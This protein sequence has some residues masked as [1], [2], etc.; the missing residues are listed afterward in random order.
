MGIILLPFFILALILLF[1]WVTFASENLGFSIMR[2]NLSGFDNSWYHPGPKWKIALW[3]LINIVFIQ[4]RQPFS[5]LRLFW[6]K[7]FG[8]NI[9]GKVVIRP[10]VRVKYPWKLHISGPVWIGED[11]WIDN[12]DTVR[13]DAHCCIS[14]GAMLLC[15]NH[16]YK[17]P[18]FDL[19][20]GPIILEEGVWIGA[21]AVVCPGT[22]CRTHS[23][24]SVG[25]VVS[26][27]MLAFTIYRGNPAVP[28]R[29]RE[30]PSQ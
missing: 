24:L 30:L 12:L 23:I 29:N 20:T 14:Q 8:A 19:I 10:G 11:V 28:V 22:V 3:Y 6:L 21:K 16:N 2:V 5:G 25:S 17:T 27:E 18:H 7:F 26:A 9:S 15:G 1:D 13:V 4:S